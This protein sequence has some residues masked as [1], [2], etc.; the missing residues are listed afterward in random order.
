MNN[1]IEMTIIMPSYNRGE[2]IAEAIESVLR[3]KVTFD[4]KLVVA[5]DGST[6]NSLDV[7][8]N[9]KDKYPDKIEIMISEK[10]H[11]LL[12]NCIRVYEKMKTKYFGMLDADDYWIDEKFLQKAYDFLEK[13]SEYVMYGCN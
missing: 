11:G 12:P 2:Y 8:D 9:Y 4:Y 1:N 5:D 6:D 3:Q 10:N 13:N 7:V